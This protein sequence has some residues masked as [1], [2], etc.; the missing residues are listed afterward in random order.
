MKRIISAQIAHN[1]V[2]APALSTSF[3]LEDYRHG[4]IDV[5]MTGFTGTIKVKVSNQEDAPDFSAP[6]T[7]TN[8]WSYLDL[9]GRDDGGGT[10]VGTTGLTGTVTTSNNSYALNADAIRW[11]A[12]D[13]EAASA[14][15]VS[16]LISGATND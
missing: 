7:L 9:K 12:I 10:V 15:D 5:I 11:A 2:D 13:V 14:G 4:V 6:S 3:L 16:V 1:A 8:Y